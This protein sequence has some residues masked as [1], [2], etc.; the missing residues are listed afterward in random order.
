MENCEN[1]LFMSLWI[2]PRTGRTLERVKIGQSFPGW[3]FLEKHVSIKEHGEFQN[4]GFVFMFSGWMVGTRWGSGNK[5]ERL[6][7]VSLHVLNNTTSTFATS[8][9]ICDR[10]DRLGSISWKVL[11]PRVSKCLKMRCCLTN[12]PEKNTPRVFFPQTRDSW[13]ALVGWKF[14]QNLG[15]EACAEELLLWCHRLHVEAFRSMIR[16]HVVTHLTLVYVGV[17]L[18]QFPQHPGRKGWRFSN[19]DVFRFWKKPVI[20]Y[21]KTIVDHSEGFP[22]GHFREFVGRW[23]MITSPDDCMILQLLF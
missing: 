7:P 14:V 23:H 8:T 17:G 1:D 4:G 15:A 19:H 2:P 20:S 10:C 12:Q 22:P 18:L 3:L 21:S 9:G 11:P 16:G 13:G 6:Q 5:L